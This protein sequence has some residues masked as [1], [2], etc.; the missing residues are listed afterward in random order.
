MSWFKFPGFELFGAELKENYNEK[1]IYFFE[2]KDDKQL[3]DLYIQMIT[4]FAAQNTVTQD[5]IDCSTQNALFKKN[6]L[7]KTQNF[8]F[9]EENILDQLYGAPQLVEEKDTK[10]IL[11]QLN[12]PQVVIKNFNTVNIEISDEKLQEIKAI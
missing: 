1:K 3:E 8:L 2:V 5:G 11:K 4:S 12:G 10:D 6:I 7:I 9:V